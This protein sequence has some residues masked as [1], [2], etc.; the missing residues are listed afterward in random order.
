MS[1]LYI[2]FYVNL[3]IHSGFWRIS[4]YTVQVWK[5]AGTFKSHF[6]HNPTAR[7]LTTSGRDN[8]RLTPRTINLIVHVNGV[9]PSRDSLYKSVPTRCTLDNIPLSGNKLSR[10]LQ[11][12]LM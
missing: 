5:S 3:M 9:D 8:F 4:I 12:L 7:S 6:M 2:F 10:S 11:N 1:G